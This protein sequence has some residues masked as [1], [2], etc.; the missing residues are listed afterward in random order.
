MVHIPFRVLLLVLWCAGIGMLSGCVLVPPSPYEG[1]PSPLYMYPYGYFYGYP[2][3]YWDWRIIPPYK[4]PGPAYDSRP[5][6]W[7]P[8]GRAGYGN[9]RPQRQ[10]WGSA[11]HDEALRTPRPPDLDRNFLYRPARR[12]DGAVETCFRERVDSGTL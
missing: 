4:L 10:A 9:R 2:Y 11:L 3:G 7:P 1:P 5:L 12:A 6:S 8:H